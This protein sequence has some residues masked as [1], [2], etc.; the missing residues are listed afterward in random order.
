MI[1]N[2]SASASSVSAPVA[3]PGTWSLVAT[4]ALIQESVRAFYTGWYQELVTEL[5]EIRNGQVYPMAGPGL[6]TELQPGITKRADARLRR[7]E[8]G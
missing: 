4:N 2:F 6:G 8:A 3:R 1:L 5:P 7:S